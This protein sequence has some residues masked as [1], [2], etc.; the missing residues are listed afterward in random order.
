[1]IKS[2]TAQRH[3]DVSNVYI[4]DPYINA[5]NGQPMVGLVRYNSNY[6]EA[7]DGH[8]WHRLSQ[9]Y[10]TIG[11]TKAA[12]EAIDWAIKEMEFEAQLKKMGEEH[13]AVQAAHE[14]FR[15][16]AEQLKATIILSQDEKS[17]S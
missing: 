13:P 9:S 16:A 2:I 15:R 6:F 7:Y 12:T 11:L 1:M 5:N 10:P 8:T 3:I 14:N 17:T 4:S